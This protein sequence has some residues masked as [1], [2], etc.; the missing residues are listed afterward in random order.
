MKRKREPKYRNKRTVLDG[1]TFDSKKEATRWAHLKLLEQAQHIFGLQRQVAY[2]L[3]PR[4]EFER[5]KESPELRYV[6]DFVYIEKGCIV[7]EDSKS[8][9]TRK[10]SSYR[11][12]RHLM[13]TV[14]GIEILET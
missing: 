7:V 5:S 1:I 13:M 2:V 14:H 8:E 3:A 4:A 12:K 10:E 11:I 6:A 9:P